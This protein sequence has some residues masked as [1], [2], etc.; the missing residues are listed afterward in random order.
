MS[1]NLLLRFGLSSILCLVATHAHCWAQLDFGFIA[2]QGLPAAEE[3]ARTDMG[4]DAYPVLIAST[5]TL[6][7]E[8]LP[9][10]LEFNLNN[11]KATVWMY[12]F[13]SPSSEEFGT[14][15]VARIIGYQ[16]FPVGTLPI[17]LPG[18]FITEVNATGTYA[19]SDDM[20]G[21]LKADT[22]FT[23][24]RS[25]LPNAQPGFVTF[26][27]LL[28]EG[29]PELPNDFPLGQGTWTLSFQGGGDSTMTCFVASETGETFCRRIYGLPTVSVP[30]E[31]TAAHNAQLTVAPNPASGSVTV[32]VSGVPN[33]VLTTSKLLLYNQAGEL[34]LDLTESFSNNGYSRASF[35]ANALPSGLYHCRLVGETVEKHVGLIVVE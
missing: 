28:S 24:Y 4:S 13:Y 19:D 26:G 29:A 33:S 5:G 9:L 12:V 21:R 20:I 18:E 31:S 15:I 2:L 22:A 8:E 30:N 11:G 10:P 16:V 32:Q 23:K 14:Y 17:P 3:Q 6:Q 1:K 34:V 7:V 27:Q 25:D 35:A